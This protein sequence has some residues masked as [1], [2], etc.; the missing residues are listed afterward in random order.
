MGK[1]HPSRSARAGS[2]RLVQGARRELGSRNAS[3]VEGDV[4]S[5]AGVR[6]GKR[7]DSS[8]RKPGS[9]GQLEGSWE[10]KGKTQDTVV[11]PA[12]AK[13]ILNGSQLAERTIV[14]VAVFTALRAS[15]IFGLRWEA[16]DFLN[17]K[18]WIRRNVDQGEGRQ[19]QVCREPH[20]RSLVGETSF[21]L[22]GMEATI[23][24]HEANGLRFSITEAEREEA[25][26]WFTVRKG[27]R[28]AIPGEARR[29]LQRLSR[30]LWPSRFSPQ[31]DQRYD[32]GEA[33]RPK[34]RSVSAPARQQQ[35]HH[36]RIRTCP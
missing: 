21:L 35:S 15:E 31:P 29:H 26:Q 27:L 36:G 18:I 5:R 10:G 30:S 22:D 6:D 23:P 12:V 8:G 7:A 33:G 14:L 24:L 1:T 34:N 32:W 28:Q 16:V 2:E 9:Q 11:P 3:E 13:A 25:S 17:Q 20:P 19:G 4:P